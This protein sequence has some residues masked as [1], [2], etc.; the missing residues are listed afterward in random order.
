[1]L[2]TEALFHICIYTSDSSEWCFLLSQMELQSLLRTDLQAAPVSL[3]VLA[4]E[5]NWTCR[6]G[7]MIDHSGF[8][9]YSSQTIFAFQHSFHYSINPKEGSGNFPHCGSSSRSE[10]SG[11]GDHFSIAPQITSLT[12]CLLQ[13]NSIQQILTS[14]TVKQ[15]LSRKSHLTP[16]PASFYWG[17]AVYVITN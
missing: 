6:P 13:F 16:S 4:L 14:L 9:D 17:P 3:L 12:C 1:M 8:M 10:R 7:W 11:A 5:L 15:A 2:H